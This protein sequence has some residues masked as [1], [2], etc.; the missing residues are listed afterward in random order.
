[1]RVFEKRVT[2]VTF[3][4]EGEKVPGDRWELH[5]EKSHDLCSSLYIIRIVRQTGDGRG[6]RH[7]WKKRNV[8]RFLVGKCEGDKT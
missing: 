7:V 5:N 4:A 6:M 2:E 1:M 3:G 8:C